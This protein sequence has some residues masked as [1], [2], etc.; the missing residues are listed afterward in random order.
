MTGILAL[1]GEAF[2]QATGEQGGR[3]LEILIVAL[4]L[5]GEQDVHRVMPV[6]G[7]LR[8]EMGTGATEKPGW[9]VVVLHH[10]VR[11]PVARR[12]S[13]GFDHH[14][15]EALIRDGLHRIITEAVEAVLK[16]PIQRVLEE[17]VAYLGF[18]EVDGG[19]P[20]GMRA[21]VEK[22][23]GVDVD[24]RAVWPKVVVNHVEHDRD[25]QAMSGVDQGFQL[26]WR[27]VG[28]VWR[29]GQHAV[30][31][32]VPRAG[33][34]ADRHQLQHRHPKLGQLRQ[35]LTDAGEAAHQAHMHF[36]DD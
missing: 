32:P 17:V 25:A 24:V 19:T 21:L 22:R 33:E 36:V 11:G 26:V 10:E 27:T 1:I 12:I 14:Q 3:V 28:G 34:V 8:V 4:R 30:I 16:Q 31:A 23:L 5:P 29:I 2:R 9:V 18:G 15:D 6:I 35:A 13:Q 20:D 7:P